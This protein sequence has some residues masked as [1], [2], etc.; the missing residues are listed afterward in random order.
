ML[1]ETR[2]GIEVEQR[3]REKNRENLSAYNTSH[4]TVL[5]ILVHAVNYYP[6]EDNYES[7]ETVEYF[8]RV[9]D[10]FDLFAQQTL[11]ISCDGTDEV[12]DVTH[13]EQDE[14]ARAD[15]G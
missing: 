2:D 11:M 14:A 9:P 6:L 15:R 8:S 1:Y 5:G 3:R 4:T 12:E 10:L 7:A 13:W